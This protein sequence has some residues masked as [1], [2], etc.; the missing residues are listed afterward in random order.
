MRGPVHPERAPRLGRWKTWRVPRGAPLWPWSGLMERVDPSGPWIRAPGP[1]A[2][3]SCWLGPCI[4]PGRPSSWRDGPIRPLPCCTDWAG[5]APSALQSLWKLD[6][7][8]GFTTKT[9]Q[10]AA[11][12]RGLPRL[13][14]L[15]ITSSHSTEGLSSVAWLLATGHLLTTQPP[16]G[17]FLS[18]PTPQT[19]GNI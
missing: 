17:L 2:M 12:L 13:H 6:S 5:G 1:G 4:P 9:G 7:L 10:G 3:Q 8:C 11:A 16:V 18:H 15:P 14:C 19:F